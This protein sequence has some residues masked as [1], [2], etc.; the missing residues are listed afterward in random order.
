MKD[1][2]LP[3]P[4]LTPALLRCSHYD[5]YTG[6]AARP[7]SYAIRTVYE[8]E[9]EYYIRS[10][11]GIRVD[12]QYL[13][14]SAG[15]INFRKPG[16]AVQGVPPYECYIL[17]VDMVGNTCRSGE[18]TFGSPEEAQARYDNSLLESLPD[19]LVPQKSEWFSGL[20]ENILYLQNAAGDLAQFQ[21]RSSLYLLFSEL[22]REHQGRSLSGHTRVIR[23]AVAYI[24]SHFLQPI[25]VDFLIQQSGLSRSAFHRR[26]ME[27]V[28]LSP[29]QLVT[30]LR[31]EQAKNLLSVTHTPVG[32]VG[33]LCG[34]PDHVY[35]SR[36]FRQHTGM[37][38][39]DFRRL[40]DR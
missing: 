3:T 10:E 16:Q 6:E 26:F 35:F 28:G 33:A 15:E 11:G 9:L 2:V 24:R 30:S 32:E 34:Y 23:Q 31:I 29:G 39:S 8:Y 12:G 5:G 17:I 37:S 22:F 19:K 38:P 13:P 36:I 4:F 1:T 40:A 18:F 25:S 21:L 27:E 20:L 14:F 7:E